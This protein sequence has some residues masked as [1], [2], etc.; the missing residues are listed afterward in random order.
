MG[1]PRKWAKGAGERGWRQASGEL[2]GRQTGQ[3]NPKKSL[4]SSPGFSEHRGSG[5]RGEEGSR[6][7]KF[8]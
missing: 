2:G 4:K 7:V 5:C 6:V 8:A 3:A 1:S